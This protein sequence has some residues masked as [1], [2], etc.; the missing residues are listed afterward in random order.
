MEMERKGKDRGKG[1]K[2]ERQEGTGKL[3]KKLQS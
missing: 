2:V 1:M 3:A